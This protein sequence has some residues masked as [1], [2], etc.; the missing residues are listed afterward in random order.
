MALLNTAEDLGALADA[1]LLARSRREPALFALLV[2]RYESA[3]LRRARTI[4]GDAEEAKEAVQDAFTKMYLYVDRYAA[5][6][7]A[8]F[9]SWAYTILNRVCY[10][11]Y[12]GRKRRWES[13]LELA[14][15][16]LESLADESASFLDDLSIRSEVLAALAKL[17][18]AA[19]RLLR[20]QFIEGKSQEEIAAS[21]R[22]SVPAVKTRVH[23]AKK[24]FK[25]VYDTQ[26]HD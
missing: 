5:Q 8:T 19:A 10:T 7:G 23:R 13:R 20:L 6:E 4:L 18:E 21:E 16:H 26:H 14:P 25:S 12:Q 24:L 3:F 11:R 2:R 15:E 9:A 22:L 17:P 1:E